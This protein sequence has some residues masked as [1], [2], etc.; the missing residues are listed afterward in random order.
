MHEELWSSVRQTSVRMRAYDGAD[1]APAV[2]VLH[3]YVAGVDALAEVRGD[4]DPFAVLREQGCH[5]LALDWP[6]HGRSGGPRGHLTYRMAMDAAA[7]GVDV[8]A[9]RWGRPTALFGVGVG[10][11]LAFY[12]ALEDTRVA[13][14]AS[15]GLLDLRNVR[16]VLHRLRQGI[17]LPVAAQLARVLGDRAQRRVRVPVSALFSR[18]DIAGDPQIAAR[19]RRHPQ[20][21]SSYTLAGLASIFCAP[22]DKPDVRAQRTSLLAAVGTHDPLLPETSTRAF[23]QQLSCPTEL[24]LLPGAGHQLLLEHPRALLPTVADFVQR[25]AAQREAG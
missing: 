10:G 23:T 8:A 7:C 19:L 9:D 12:A 3:G 20:A 17:T 22:E 6:G 4:L 14:V 18:A 5:V 11:V 15:A 21:V 1:G 13:A 25:N 2:V 16:P 24:W